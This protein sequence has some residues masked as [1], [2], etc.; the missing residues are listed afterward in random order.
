MLWGDSEA[1]KQKLFSMRENLQVL[2]YFN[3]TPKVIGYSCFFWTAYVKMPIAIRQCAWVNKN[4]YS[5][6]QRLN[7]EY[8]ENNQNNKIWFEQWLV[9]LTDGDGTF[10]IAYQ[11]EKWNLVYKIALSRYNL[12]ALYYV[13]TKLGV[14][15]VNK[16]GT[17]GQ[18]V[19]R[20]RKKLAENIFPIFDKYPLLTSKQFD[21]IK[22]K[23][24]YLILENNNLSK[25]E[26]YKCLFELKNK[27]LP[28]NYMSSAWSK[29]KIPFETTQDVTSIMTKPW[30]V[31]FIE[32][33]GSFYLVSKDKT[34]IVPLISPAISHLNVN[35]EYEAIKTVITPEWLIGLAEV[36]G[37]FVILSDC[38]RC[39]T[40]F[41]I[42]LRQDVLLLYL[43][44]RILHI[45]NN[46]Q[47]DPDTKMFFLSTKNYRAISNII[48]YFEGKFKGM[49]SLEFKLWQKAN[50]SSDKNIKKFLKLRDISLKV[51]NKNSVPLVHK[52]EFSCVAITKFATAP[53]WKVLAYIT[54]VT[55]QL[56]MQYA[57]YSR[58][59]IKNQILATK[60]EG[61][62]S[63][64]GTRNFMNPG[65]SLRS[66]N[67]STDSNSINPVVTYLN[68]DT[69]KLQI[70]KENRKKS[71]VYRWTNV[72]NGK[73][74]IGS[75][76]DLGE[77]FYRYYSIDY[78]LKV[79][80]RTR[81]YIYSSLL[82]NGYSNF[83]LEVL[84]Y[85]KK[86]DLL[87]REQYY[88]DILKPEYN[89]LKTPYSSL[90]LKHTEE[91]KAR[92]SKLALGRTF[93][94]ETLAKLSR[95][96]MGKGGKIVQVVDKNTGNS[97]EYVSMNQA[98]L[99][100]GGTYRKNS[101]LYIKS[102]FIIW[103]IC[104]YG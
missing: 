16:D 78:L 19:I 67:Y 44:K 76:S 47:F 15:S 62:P 41:N 74:Y 92:M 87:N 73:S 6:H 64:L 20:D 98:A 35:S 36:A 84:E 12:R 61:I 45:K 39:E 57:V 25:D 17:K 51:R 42:Y 27:T 97:V 14:G 65:F 104:D 22:L 37:N 56:S 3:K 55:A 95:A 94:K 85:C 43:I 33:E 46:I 2:K 102:N 68:A 70:I 30:V 86:K 77:R 71:G 4:Y 21:Y 66:C 81:S 7:K 34:R 53:R 82:K 54:R 40:E 48:K 24:A 49:K 52:R 13:K 103:T 72:I 96:N 69:L 29:T 99:A 9:G 63:R 10:H 28:V 8:L 50:Y 101:S 11:N 100:F 89:I 75:S 93:S 90:G 58:Y 1:N 59:L 31:G 23:Q 38:G 26:K 91:T 5:T 79:L 88:F 60:A 83:K 18:F 32:A 80:A